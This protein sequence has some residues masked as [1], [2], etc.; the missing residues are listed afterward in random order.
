[1]CLMVPG[2]EVKVLVASKD[3]TC[4]KVLDSSQRGPYRYMTYELGEL[5]TGGLDEVGFFN[6]TKTRRPYEYMAVNQ[7]F[8]SFKSREGARVEAR[9]WNYDYDMAV[10]RAV[11]PA[12]ARYISGIFVINGKEYRSYASNA[13][14][15]LELV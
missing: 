9:D 6:D 8:H 15:V 5:K 7:G 13:L 3:V 14:M 12:G 1:M 2:N 11:I 4:Y 10:Y